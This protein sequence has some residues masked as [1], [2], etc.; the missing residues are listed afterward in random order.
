MNKNGYSLGL[1]NDQAIGEGNSF[2]ND[3]LGFNIYSQI[4]GEAIINSPTPF[5]AGI[6][7]EWGTGKTSLMRMIE[8]Y[9]QDQD[10]KNVITIWFNAWRFEKD[11]HPLIPLV[12]HIVQE[13]KRNKSFLSN[14]SKSQI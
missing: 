9:L 4:I 8:K 10:K 5:T 12:A 6:F 2:D 7:G 3:G 13:A 11:E 1:L 14:F